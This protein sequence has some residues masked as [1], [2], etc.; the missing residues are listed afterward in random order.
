MGELLIGSHLPSDMREAINRAK[1]EG[2]DYLTC[3]IRS[4]RFEVI[5]LLESSGFYLADLGVTLR[6]ATDVFLNDN[7]KKRSEKVRQSIRMGTFRDIPMLKKMA[8]S[9]FPESR[10]F[11]D[12]FFSRGEAERLYRTW[13]ENS[14]RGQAADV[15]YIIPQKG[16]ITCRRSRENSGEIVLIGV[17]KGHRGKGLGRALIVKAMEWFQRQKITTVTVRTQLKNLRAIN[18][19]LR[20]GFVVKEADMVFGRIL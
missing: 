11:N 14:V 12:P 15:V 20:L 9:L 18:F 4:P 2:F 10:F 8:G 5:R 13:V 17:K 7:G 6:V 3:K 1:E 19:Y 16:F